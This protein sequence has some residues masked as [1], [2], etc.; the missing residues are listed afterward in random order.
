MSCFTVICRIICKLHA[1]TTLTSFLLHSF[2]DSHISYIIYPKSKLL[3]KK[4]ENHIY[5]TFFLNKER[6]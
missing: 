4:V 5:A 2:R 6:F 3:K 1:T